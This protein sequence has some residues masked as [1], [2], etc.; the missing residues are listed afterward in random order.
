MNQSPQKIPDFRESHFIT[1]EA[2]YW[3]GVSTLRSYL[4]VPARFKLPTEDQRYLNPSVTFSEDV[5][6]P[7]DEPYLLD[8]FGCY[9]YAILVEAPKTD[10]FIEKLG[11]FI[12]SGAGNRIKGMAL[13]YELADLEHEIRKRKQKLAHEQ[14]RAKF[15]KREGLS[16]K[17]VRRMEELQPIL[18]KKELS[19]MFDYPVSEITRMVNLLKQSEGRYEEVTT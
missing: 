2:R 14:L 12:I 17:Q 7:M 8:I 3:L 1:H 6:D 15:H 4:H 9:L 16:K 11:R 13:R 10:A 18:S 19:A 5:A